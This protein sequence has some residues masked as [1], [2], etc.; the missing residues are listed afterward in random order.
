MKRILIDAG[1]RNEPVFSRLDESM[2]RLDA[3]D[4]DRLLTIDPALGRFTLDPDAYR[5]FEPKVGAGMTA[6]EVGGE[7]ACSIGTV[8]RRLRRARTWMVKELT[9]LMS[10]APAG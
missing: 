9:P 3:P 6:E 4:R 5:V 2:A 7:I 10:R 8:N 1:R